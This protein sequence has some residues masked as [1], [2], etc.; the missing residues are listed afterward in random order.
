MFLKNKNFFDSQSPVKREKESA[1]NPLLAENFEE[2]TRVTDS[3]VNLSFYDKA[4]MER[5]QKLEDY[6]RE[7]NR[8]DLI[9]QICDIQEYLASKKFTVAVVGEFNRGKSTLVNRLIER[10]IIP[11]SDIPTTTLPIRVSGGK[12]EI[13]N[14]RMGAESKTYP[15]TEKSWEAIEKIR[16]NSKGSKGEICLKRNCSLLM[17]HDLEIIDTPGVN[18]QIKGDFSM[19]E[20]ALSGCDCAVLPMAAISPFSESERLFLQERIIMKKIP[21]I[22]VVLT[23]LD[24]VEENQRARVIE[25]VRLKLESLNAEIPLYLSS[26]GLVEGWEEKSGVKAIRK[27]ILDWMQESSH[28][29]LK[30]DRACQEMKTIIS[31]LT[32]IYT[33][34]LEI[35]AEKEEKRKEVAEQKKQ[36]LL[37]SSQIQWDSLEI[38]ML[39]RCNQ[40]F[41]WIRNMTEDRQQDIIEKLLLE[42]NHVTSPKDWW[43]KDYPYRMKMEMISLGNALENNLHAFYTRDANWLNQVLQEKYSSVIPPQNQRIADKDVFRSPVMLGDVELQDMKRARMISRV[44]TGA[45]TIGGYLMGGMIG[46]GPLGMAIGIGGGILSEVFMNKR[47]ETQKQDLSRIM[48]EE[49]PKIFSDSIATVEQNIREVYVSTILMMK[50][51]CSDWVKVKCDAID[52]AQKQAED[53]KHEESIRQKIECLKKIGV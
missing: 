21:R 16:A 13:L 7:A 36:Q 29:S 31:D 20:Q 53:P 27:Q 6:C 45:A 38:E 15:L 52:N 26:E 9:M 34:Q 35:I 43:E 4:F 30:K 5:L 1:M 50:Q 3:D 11:T 46:F 17:E 8:K 10:D 51:S 25:S 18:S 22:M 32:A 39:K 2:E 12:Q 28:V 41:E 47:V 44:S 37:R 24:L 48:K 33:C 49:L 23:K 40:N 42:L 14:L 19:A